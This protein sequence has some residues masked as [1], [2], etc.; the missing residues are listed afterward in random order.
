[1]HVEPHET[2]EQLADRI[3]A[4]PVARIARRLMA[5]RLAM[6]GQTALQIVPQVLLSERQVRAWV[7]RYNAEGAAALADRAGRGRKGPL[8]AAQEEQLRARLRAGPTDADG[9]CT[10]RGAD[11]RRILREEFG[12]LRSLQAIYDLLRRLGF[13]LLRPR[14]RHPGADPAARAALK[15]SLPARAAAVA[16]EH[17][18]EHVEVWFEDE[19]RFGQKGTRTTVWA[20]RGTRPTAPKQTACGNLYVLSAVCPA[21]GRAEGLIAPRLNAAV[22]QLLPDQLAATIPRGTHVV[23]V[24]DGAGYHVAKALRVPANLTVIRLPPD[25]PELN[26][27]E[28]LWLYLRQHHWSNRVYPTIEDVEAAAVAGW[29]AV[30]LDPENIKSICRCEYV[31]AGD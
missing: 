17:P 16:A 30:C 14:P 8:S 6:L 26:P 11:V 25:S 28:R 20:E 2:P 1:M 22:V 27:V 18:G 15:K 12:I 3:R 5:A 19:A 23:L 10:L 29:R 4:E 21:G 31:P 7:A 24:W 13:T 9:V